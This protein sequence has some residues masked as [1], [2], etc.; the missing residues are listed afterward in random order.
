MT[1]ERWSA[2]KDILYEAMEMPA[3]ERTA[4]LERA[5][6]GDSALRWEVDTLLSASGEKDSLLDLPITPLAEARINEGARIGDYQVGAKLGEGGMG[7]VFQALDT[8]LGRQVALKVMHSSLMVNEERREQFI[9]EARAASALNH[10]NI[11]TIHDL[12]RYEDSDVIVMEFVAGNVLSELLRNGPLEVEELVPIAT[13]IASAL[14]T[15]HAAGVVHRDLKPANILL[16]SD[17]IVKVLDFGAAKLFEAG[18]AELP[19]IPKGS[20]LG[21]PSYMSPEQFRDGKVD[22]RSDIFSF[23]AMLYEMVS[24]RKAFM[25]TT[26]ASTAKAVLESEPPM[27]ESAPPAGLNHLIQDCLRKDP[28]ARPQSMGAIRKG[29]KDLAEG[30]EIARILSQIPDWT[31]EPPPIRR[32]AWW[33]G[34]WEKVRRRPA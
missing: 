16:R 2:V 29:L 10:P 6:A 15:T 28:A 24:G 8:K 7:V 34:I 33:K 20:I 11:I 27:F 23:G 5:C 12:L 3:I 19:G 1:P 25:G 22:P 14:E 18:T 30:M 4:F 9:Q 26:V 31:G 32:S 17:G 21:T 13:Q